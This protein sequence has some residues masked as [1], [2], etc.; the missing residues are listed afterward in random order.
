MC[1]CVTGI[2]QLNQTNIF[3]LGDQKGVRRDLESAPHIYIC[4]TL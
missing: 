4:V 2:W 1:H 3:R